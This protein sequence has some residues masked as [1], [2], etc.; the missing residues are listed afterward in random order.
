M[1]IQDEVILA[2]TVWRENRGGGLSGMQSVANVIM[3]RVKMRK[4][5]A[6]TECVRAEQ[7]SSMT[8]KGDPELTLWPN[9]GDLQWQAALNIAAQAAAGAL[10]DITGGADLYYAP[11]GQQW[12]QRFTLPNGTQIPFPD[13]WN[14]A[15]V[16]YTCTVAGQVFFK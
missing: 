10:E 6:Y 14:E 13:H 7:F 15:A 1:T 8:A 12:K 9:D 3:N 2:L 4:S 16:Q 11:A 5:D